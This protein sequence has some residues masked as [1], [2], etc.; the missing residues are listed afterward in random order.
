MMENHVE[1]V[2]VR[3]DVVGIITDNDE[4]EEIEYLEDAFQG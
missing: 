2:F 1:E 4:V 3:F